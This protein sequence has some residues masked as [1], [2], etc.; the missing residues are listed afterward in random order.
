MISKLREKLKENEIFFSTIATLLL[1]LMAVVVTINSNKLL[2]NQ[3]EVERMVN[4]PD[5]YISREYKLNEETSSFDEVELY[6][7]KLSGVAKN[8]KVTNTALLEI[9]FAD[10]LQKSFETTFELQ[11]MYDQSFSGYNGESNIITKLSGYRN[12]TRLSNF[13][14]SFELKMKDFGYDYVSTKPKI[15]IKIIYQDFSGQFK[16]EFYESNNRDGIKLYENYDE[17]MKMKGS[18]LQI[19]LDDIQQMNIGEITNR[20]LRNA[21]SV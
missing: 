2:Y 15:F 3:I 16:E 20:I 9:K 11:S 7:K 6:I 10:S 14:K 17:Q 5:F 19:Y 21:K 18:S 4:Q 8:I 1:S 12:N 13:R